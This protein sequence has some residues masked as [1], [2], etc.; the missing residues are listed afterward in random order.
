[1]NRLIAVTAL[2]F[3]LAGLNAPACPPLRQRVVV[4]A[5]AVVAVPLVP[6]VAVPAYSVGYDPA[7][8]AIVAELRALREAVEKLRPGGGAGVL[9]LKGVVATRCAAC[10]QD[11]QAEAK[12]AGFVLLEKDGSL[13]PF[14]L[15]ERRRMKQLVDE[16]KMPP[17]NPLSEA[18]KSLFKKE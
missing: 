12:G 11:D 4:Q 5:Q 9:D 6:V 7:V 2:V 17:K 14:S 1:M 15:P 8:G 18:E 16:G 3:L 13:P 10:H